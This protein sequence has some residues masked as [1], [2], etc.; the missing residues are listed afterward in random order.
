MNSRGI[1]YWSSY[2]HTI[3]LLER[4]SYENHIRQLM[5]QVFQKPLFFFTRFAFFHNG[6]WLVFFW[7]WCS[8]AY[9]CKDFI[10]HIYVSCSMYSLVLV[11]TL[12]LQLKLSA[13]IKSAYHIACNVVTV[14]AHTVYCVE[15]EHIN[16]N[17]K[18][19][20]ISEDSFSVS[21]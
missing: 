1:S 19:K 18:S 6:L 16:W 9:F 10:F 4:T 3:E 11:C 15:K 5:F 20:S 13:F 7:K 21:Y 8:W 2:H 17:Y 12:W 14:I